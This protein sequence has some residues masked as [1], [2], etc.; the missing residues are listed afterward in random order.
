M[1]RRAQVMVLNVRQ[2]LSYCIAQLIYW[3]GVTPPQWGMSC[4]LGFSNWPGD[5]R[6]WRSACRAWPVKM[7]TTIRSQV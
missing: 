5:P 4:A 1:S 2:I 7:L 6:G 3:V